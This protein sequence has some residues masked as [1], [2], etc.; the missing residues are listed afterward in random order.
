MND[1]QLVC[2]E[3]SELWNL[4]LGKNHCCKQE[5]LGWILSCLQSFVLSHKC[6]S[7]WLTVHQAS[8]SVKWKFI[9]LGHHCFQLP[10]RQQGGLSSPRCRLGTKGG[11]HQNWHQD[12]VL[13]FPSVSQAVN[14]QHSC[15]KSFGARGHPLHN[16][17]TSST[18][19]DY[20]LQAY[21]SEWTCEADEVNCIKPHCVRN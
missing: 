14:L 9:S 17:V 12:Q 15:T 2:W 1:R 19:N 16:G 13:A 18:S 21:L 11:T 7:L 8:S 4:C 3:G 20:L 10:Q 6:L 5:D